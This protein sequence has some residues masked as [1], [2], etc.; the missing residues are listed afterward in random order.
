[1]LARI[2][3]AGSLAIVGDDDAVHTLV[4]FFFDIGKVLLCIVPIDRTR[5]LEVEAQHLLVSADDA[6]LRRG[7]AICPDEPRIVDAACRKFIEQALAVCVIAD[8]ARN[9]DI[10]PKERKVVRDV[11]RT[12]EGFTRACHMRD[13][14]RRLGRDARDLTGV[15]FIQ[16]H[17]ADDEDVAAHTLLR[18]RFADFCHIHENA[19][20]CNHQKTNNQSN[21]WALIPVGRT[22]RTKRPAAP[23]GASPNA[24]ST[25]STT[26]VSKSI[27]R[28][29]SQA[30]CS[31]FSASI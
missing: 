28:T 20:I 24:P 13:R 21:P 12:T 8:I 16:H 18:D 11:R 15:V 5:I 9:A 22:G 23:F 1:M 25:C 31:P 26:R 3:R 30:G 7:R 6:D 27:G 2:L 29:S 4:E 14:H 17:I 10:R 19:P